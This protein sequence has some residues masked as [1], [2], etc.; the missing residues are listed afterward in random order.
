ME[1]MGA[2]GRGNYLCV[3]APL[4]ETMLHCIAT[5]PGLK[6]APHARTRLLLSDSNGSQIYLPHRFKR[7]F[8]E[9]IFIIQNKLWG[10]A[11]PTL[12]AHHPW[13]AVY[14]AVL[15]SP[16]IWNN[17]LFW[18]GSLHKNLEHALVLH[19]S[20]IR[21]MVG[22]QPG[23]SSR[24]TFWSLCILT[25]ISINILDRYLRYKGLL[26][27]TLYSPQLEHGNHRDCRTSL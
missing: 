3:T 18:G 12:M 2:V 22:H 20:V 7:Y 1:H 9:F 6:S 17:S 23:A 15:I 5:R 27:K 8:H 26:V 16:Q 10:S 4:L 11:P 13:W 21:S 25:T 14:C 24:E 19:K